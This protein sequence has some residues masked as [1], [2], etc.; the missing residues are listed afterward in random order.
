MRATALAGLISAA[1]LVGTPTAASAADVGIQVRLGD[2]HASQVHFSYRHR[3][4]GHRRVP[5]Y[6]YGVAA[7]VG[8]DRGYAEGLEEGI[9]DARR[10]RR[11]EFWREK[12]YR[13]ADRGYRSE[14]GPRHVYSKAFR[15]GYESGYRRGYA[16]PG[17]RGHGYRAPAHRHPGSRDWC[18]DSHRDH[19]GYVYERPW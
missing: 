3:D 19:G 15:E 8:Y 16:G 6:G 11:F 12:T 7:R 2:G 4:A 1:A 17:Y 10:H 9:E 14:Y 5:G 13:K 18:H